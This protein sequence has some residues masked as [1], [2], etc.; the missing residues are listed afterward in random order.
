MHE[1]MDI[2]SCCSR[3]LFHSLQGAKKVLAGFFGPQNAPAFRADFSF[4]QRAGIGR[5]KVRTVAAFLIILRP[6]LV[7]GLGFANLAGLSRT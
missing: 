7:L 6:M 4:D 1:K 2:F 5:D 3:T